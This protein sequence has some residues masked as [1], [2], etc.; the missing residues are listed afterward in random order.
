MPLELAAVLEPPYFIKEAQN[1]VVPPILNYHPDF[2][3]S[4]N[5]LAHS[6]EKQQDKTI[7]FSV[8]LDDVQVTSNRL[9]R[10]VRW[11]CVPLGRMWHSILAWC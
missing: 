6:P 10:S 3:L 4:C 8:M 7:L 11:H 1:Q 9:V 2:A 5:H